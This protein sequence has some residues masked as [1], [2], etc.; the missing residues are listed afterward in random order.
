MHKLGLPA[1]GSGL[2]ILA[3]MV[4]ILFTLPSRYTCT[5]SAQ[6]TTC[7]DLVATNEALQLENHNL[8]ATLESQNLS[9]APLDACLVCMG[10]VQL[11]LTEL[12][13]TLEPAVSTTPSGTKES[14][15]Q[16]F[17]SDL[18]VFDLA[19]I[20]QIA[21]GELRIKT[22]TDNSYMLVPH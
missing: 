6:E 12:S 17:T 10:A 15:S 4:G 5:V 18:G 3:V 20:G 11:R 14:F 21:D 2:I 7:T 9:T 19:D 13:T 8:R 1:F 16:D 22:E